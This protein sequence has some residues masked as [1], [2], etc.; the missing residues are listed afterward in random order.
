[1]ELWDPH[2][3]RHLTSIQETLTSVG[4]VELVHESAAEVWRANRERYEPEELFDDPFILSHQ[5]TRNLANRLW[6]EVRE[7]RWRSAGVGASREYQATVLHVRGLDIRL[8]KA[9]H[10]AGRAPDFVA[11]F[12]WRASESRLAAA[13]RN[14]AAY[15]P[16]PRIP[17]MQPLFDVV[18][19]DAAQAVRACRD[20]FLVWGAELVTGLTA[21]WLGLPTTSAERWLAVCPLW[22]DHAGSEST[23]SEPSGIGGDR[24]AEE[25][26]DDAPAFDQRRAPAPVVTLRPRDREAGRR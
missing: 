4:L 22:R 5:S 9:P 3:E 25:F 24:P 6:A 18:Q 11:D 8:V 26:S 16:P 14:H 2:A 10:S 15:G 7:P 20:V 23:S 1:M 21:G 17:W 12:D 13:A 19:P